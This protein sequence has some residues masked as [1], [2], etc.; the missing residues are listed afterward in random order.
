MPFKLAI[1]ELHI[2]DLHR[3]MGFDK[4]MLSSH[5]LVT[6]VIDIEEFYNDGY[7]DDIAILKECYLMWLYQPMQSENSII[8]RDSITHPVIRNYKNIIDNGNYIKLDIVKV[9]YFGDVEMVAI[10]KTFWLRLI[11]RRWKRIYKERNNIINNRKN[12]ITLRAR[13]MIGKWSKGLHCKR[14]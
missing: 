5:Y 14:V 6:S 9:E 1:C 8:V 2:P 13:E 3:Y 4:T 10:I 12:I 7:T 11:Q